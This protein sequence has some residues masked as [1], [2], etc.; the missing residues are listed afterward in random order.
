[1]QSAI[2]ILKK[3]EIESHGT[4]DPR[5]DLDVLSQRVIELA[6]E[7]EKLLDEKKS[8]NLEIV[9]I[10]PLGEFSIDEVKALEE[11]SGKAV[12]F[13]SVK[14]TSEISRDDLIFIDSDH[15]YDYYLSVA[16]ERIAHKQ[17]WIEIVLER[18]IDQLR[19]R[20]EQAKKELQETRKILHDLTPYIERLKRSLIPSS[21]STT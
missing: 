16:D 17:G 18:S 20:L 19:V 1:M 13:F 6:T 14:H 3:Q 9:K 2:A 5:L 21:K 4:I 11:E 8:L 15:E 10:A 12:Q 7:E